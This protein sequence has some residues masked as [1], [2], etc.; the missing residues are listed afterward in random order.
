MRITTGM[1]NDSARKAGIPVNHTSLL[2]YVNKTNNGNDL[3][4][5]INSGMNTSAASKLN[6]ISK[7]NYEKFEKAAQQLQDSISKLTDEK[8]NLFTQART[9]Q[10]TGKLTDSVTDMIEK[11]NE[12]VKTLSKSTSTQDTFYNSMLKGVPEDLAQSLSEIGITQNKDGTLTIDQEKLKTM[13][14]DKLEKMFGKDTTLTK[15]LAFIAGR[16]ES[17][18]AATLDSMSSTYGQSGNIMSGF[19]SSKYDYL[20]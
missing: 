14:A 13:D 11:Y 18:A 8:N 15:K 9:D 17:N 16:I 4:N 6:S 1:L 20:G 10:D 7:T 2:D 19:N 12:L 3:M 5:A